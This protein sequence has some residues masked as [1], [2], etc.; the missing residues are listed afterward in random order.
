M[1]KHRR[2]IIFMIRLDDC[3][4]GSLEGRADGGERSGIVP[5]VAS[6]DDDVLSDVLAA[7]A[8]GVVAEGPV[9]LE[10]LS[11]VADDVGVE[12]DLVGG[13]PPEIVVEAAESGERNQIRSAWYRGLQSR[14]DKRT[15]RG[16]A[17]RR[18]SALRPHRFAL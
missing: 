6:D 3:L 11:E 12:S 16:I 9:I 2:S 10:E 7:E 14:K 17:R 13:H 8:E 5:V 18:W 4:L 15:Q 1:R